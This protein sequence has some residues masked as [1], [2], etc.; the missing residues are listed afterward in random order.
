MITSFLEC[1]QILI[2]I[3]EVGLLGDRGGTVFKVLRYKLEGRWFDS[4]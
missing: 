4:R 3:S 1:H 2:C